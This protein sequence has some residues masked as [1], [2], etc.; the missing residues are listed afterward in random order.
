MAAKLGRRYPVAAM[1]GVAAQ[2]RTW[3]VRDLIEAAQRESRGA[4]IPLL[5]RRLT[6]RLAEHVDVVKLGLAGADDG[7]ALAEAE[8]LLLAIDAEL[9]DGSG[10]VLQEIGAALAKRHLSRMGSYGAS[11]DLAGTFYRLKIPLF[12]HPFV[13]VPVSFRVTPTA[14]G[15]E[16]E[17]GVPG[18]PRAT[19]ALRFLATGA[20]A[21]CA[22][23]S[24]EASAGDL[25]LFG[26]TL[27]DRARIA[28]RYPK[29]TTSAPEL[30]PPPSFRRK[31]SRSVRAITGTQLRAEVDK[32]LGSTPPP[33]RDRGQ[34]GLRRRDDS[35][36][37]EDDD[38]AG[39][40]R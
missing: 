27:G 16:L 5:R 7:I 39:S 10:R 25:R 14:S 22:S 15:F 24:I 4:A 6:P 18:H 12:E 35:T 8:E 20:I 23:A 38:A 37:T 40:D 11:S 29:R 17:L 2:I 1:G 21:A 34:T 19:K 9:G 33:E 3:F 30:E 28:A 32:I 13:G 26:E 36:A 31:T